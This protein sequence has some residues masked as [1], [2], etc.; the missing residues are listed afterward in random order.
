MELIALMR[1]HLYLLRYISIATDKKGGGQYCF[2][3]AVCEISGFEDAT[4]GDCVL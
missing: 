1:M 2:V 3:E 4:Y